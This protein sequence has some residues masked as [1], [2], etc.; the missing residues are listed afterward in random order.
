MGVGVLLFRWLQGCHNWLGRVPEGRTGPSSGRQ[1][2]QLGL[3]EVSG[4]K[5]QSSL[6]V[7][8][9][10]FCCVLPR[11]GVWARSSQVASLKAGVSWP[12]LSLTTFLQGERAW[13][14]SLRPNWTL[15]TGFGVGQCLPGCPPNS[16]PST[17]ILGWG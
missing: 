6:C 11:R 2:R 15:L 8:W 14:L 3:E 7:A 12:L 16:Q 13:G 9:D 17:P 1:R 4:S 10:A 5:G